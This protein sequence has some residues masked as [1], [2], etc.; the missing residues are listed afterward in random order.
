MMCI[1]YM[2]FVTSLDFKLFEIALLFCS[3]AALLPT[4]AVQVSLK[5]R[6]EGPVSTHLGS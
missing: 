1:I 5:A 2:V 4:L 3:P 6:K